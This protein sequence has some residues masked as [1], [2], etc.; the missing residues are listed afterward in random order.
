[1]VTDAGWDGERV[2]EPRT[3]MIDIGGVLLL[4]DEQFWGRLQNEL[5]VDPASDA[6]TLFYGSDGPWPA[7]KTGRMDYATY[8]GHLATVLRVDA[9]RLARLRAECEWVVNG[10]AVDWLRAVRERT[11]LEVIAVSNADTML[12][13]RLEKLGLA[14]LFHHV[15]NSA[16]VGSAKPDPDIYRHA[17]ALTT[18]PA[19]DCLFIDDQLRNI[20]PAAALGLRTALYTP[21]PEFAAA[22]P[23]GLGR[24]YEETCAKDAG[25]TRAPRTAIPMA[26]GS[27]ARRDAQG[28]V[29]LNT[30]RKGTRHA[31]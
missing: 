8:L 22:L 23:D 11:G 29:G 3:V 17:L 21:G 13:T 10:P 24:L 16:R 28:F 2:G 9:S 27:P 30:K 31:Q 25:G 14:P 7:C 12:E 6:E 1:M 26:E 20:P 5:G 4:P 19:G 18:S 15:V